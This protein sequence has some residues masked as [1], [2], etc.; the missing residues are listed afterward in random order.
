MYPTPMGGALRV[1]ERESGSG[2]GLALTG[3][4]GFGA[5]L[6]FGLVAGGLLGDVDSDRVKRAVRR[7][8]PTDEEDAV[9]E[10]LDRIEHELLDVLKHNPATRQLSLTVRAMGGGLI[11]LAGTAPDETTRELAAEL[12][13]GVM[14]ADVIVN[15]VLVEGTDTNEQ[16]AVVS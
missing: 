14:G 10:G 13:R 7:L 5:G 9:D 4:V 1:S 16:S 12:A 11:E 6:L 3:A 15:H 8:R 2:L